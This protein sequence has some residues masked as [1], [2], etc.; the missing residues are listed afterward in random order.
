MKTTPWFEADEHKPERIGI[1]QI[2]AGGIFYKHWDGCFWGMARSTPE[3]AAFAQK[4]NSEP[5]QDSFQW[6][7]LL[8]ESK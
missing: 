3:H 7:G 8:K 1:Y 2:E 5:L 6:R 4:H